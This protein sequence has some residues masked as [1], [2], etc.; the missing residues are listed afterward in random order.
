MCNKIRRIPSDYNADCDLFTAE[1]QTYLAKVKVSAADRFVVDQLRSEWE[2]H[3]EQLQEID[4]CLRGR[5]E[6]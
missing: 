6:L 5:L 3:E 1:G 2:H 4:R